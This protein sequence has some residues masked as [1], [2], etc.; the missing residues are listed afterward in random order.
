M[1]KDYQHKNQ[2]NKETGFDY[3]LSKVQPKVVP[4]VQPKVQPAVKPAQYKTKKYVLPEKKLPEDV[5]AKMENSFGQDFSDVNIHDN[6]TKAEDLG[7]KA[8]A[9]GKDVH[10]APGEFQPNTKEGQELIGHEL[11]H[12]VQQKEGKVHGGD[13]NGKDMVN[14]DPSL[15]KEADD[16]GKLASEGKEVKVNG[17]GSGVQM[18]PNEIID[19]GPTE[20]ASGLFDSKTNTYTVFSSKEKFDTLWSIAKRFGVSLEAIMEANKLGD[21][22]IKLG[23]SLIIPISSQKNIQKNSDVVDYTAFQNLSIDYK[24]SIAL[25]SNK[26]FDYYESNLM[27]FFKITFESPTEALSSSLVSKTTKQSA[28]F[29]ADTVAFEKVKNKTQA[30]LMNKVLK[31]A[32][33]E[34]GALATGVAAGAVTQALVPVPVAGFIA[35]F[36][37]GVAVDIISDHLLSMLFE[38]EDVSNQLKGADALCNLYLSHKETMRQEQEAKTHATSVMLTEIDKTGF[39]ITNQALLDNYT[40]ELKLKLDELKTLTSKINTKDLSYCDN[41]LKN[42]TLANMGAENDEAGPYTE[43]EQLFEAVKVLNERGNNFSSSNDKIIGHPDAFAYQISGELKRLGCNDNLNENYRSIICD[44]INTF[45]QYDVL[46]FDKI[47]QKGVTNTVKVSDQ[48]YKEYQGKQISLSGADF[49][50]TKNLKDQIHKTQ[51]LTWLSDEE[52]KAINNKQ[53]KV[54]LGWNLKNNHIDNTV[55]VYKFNYKLIVNGKETTWME[56]L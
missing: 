27:A 54:I 51:D 22:N 4:L 37:V 34:G 49:T 23:Q 21:T 48:A 55:S 16:A 12:V 13:V 35:G 31:V 33:R 43:K 7:A 24:D 3:S 17:L 25:H 50:N 32:V 39:Q 2:E 11:T 52:E 6:S 10:F 36:L 45:K 8:F 18:S 47:N 5:Q 53:F 40:N 56:V 9:Q 26:I 1:S 42:W 46:D 14:Q 28:Q 29:L 19:N 38:N 44:K 30:L 41:L 15:E 20:H